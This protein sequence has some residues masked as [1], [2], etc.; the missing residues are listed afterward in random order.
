[1]ATFTMVDDNGLTKA[2]ADLDAEVIANLVDQTSRRVNWNQLGTPVN[3]GKKQ[4][5]TQV[6]SIHEAS[7]VEFKSGF[8]MYE[9]EGNQ[10][11]EGQAL[12]KTYRLDLQNIEHGWANFSVQTNGANSKTVAKCMMQIGKSFG[13]GQLIHA[14]KMSAEQKKSCQLTF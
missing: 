4:V 3:F 12:Y 7:G 2:P 11:W 9:T 10:K 8:L 5:G 6:K 14:L 1:M 13:Q